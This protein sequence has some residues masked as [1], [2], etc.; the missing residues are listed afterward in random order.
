MCIERVTFSMCIEQATFVW[1]HNQF[2]VDIHVWYKRK[3]MYMC[4]KSKC[5][6]LQCRTIIGCGNKVSMSTKLLNAGPKQMHI[7][8]IH[9]LENIGKEIDAEASI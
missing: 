4:T 6:I 5:R 3:S 1:I 7:L 2:L 8:N 9:R